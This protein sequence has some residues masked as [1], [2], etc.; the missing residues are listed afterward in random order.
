MKTCNKCLVEKSL[1]L[2]QFR[3]QYNNYY[4]A[5]K[6]CRTLQIKEWREKNRTDYNAK[7]KI[8]RESRI[9]RERES[10]A[11]WK[12]SNPELVK[13]QKRKDWHATQ[14]DRVNEKRRIDREGERFIRQL[15]SE[16]NN[17]PV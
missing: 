15:E 8:W 14:K 9:E 6:E 13:E 1:E 10:R 17:Y 5:C 16:K 2:F 11:N 7:N 3:P 12:K 4:G